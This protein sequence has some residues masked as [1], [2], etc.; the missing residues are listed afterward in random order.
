MSL[1]RESLT[2]TQ[3]ARTIFWSTINLNNRCVQPE[4]SDSIQQS[5][6]G[7]CLCNTPI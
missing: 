3:R 7:N 2:T 4:T 5:Q 6:N 1:D